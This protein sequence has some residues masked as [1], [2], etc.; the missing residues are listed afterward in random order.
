LHLPDTLTCHG[1]LV[2]HTVITTSYE[3]HPQQIES[4]QQSCT[5]KAPKKSNT[6]HFDTYIQFTARPVVK[7]FTGSRSSGAWATSGVCSSRQSEVIKHIS[8]N[9]TAMFTDVVSNLRS[10]DVGPVPT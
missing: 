6:Q 2:K 3:R 4:L 10:E 8:R 9:Q 5:L 7:N 1:F